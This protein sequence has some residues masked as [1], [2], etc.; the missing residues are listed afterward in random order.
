MNCGAEG[1]TGN[2][3]R[4]GPYREQCPKSRGAHTSLA[5][6]SKYNTSTKG[7]LRSIRWRMGEKEERLYGAAD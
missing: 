3:S 4:K 5:S 2:H 1:C 7:V 6:H